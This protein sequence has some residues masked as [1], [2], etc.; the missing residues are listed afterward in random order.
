[1]ENHTW[2]EP[3]DWLARDR[4]QYAD[5]RKRLALEAD[6]KAK[7]S[8]RMKPATRERIMRVQ[9]RAKES[10]KYRSDTQFKLRR[11][12]RTRMKRALLAQG[13]AKTFQSHVRLLGCTVEH[14]QKHIESQFEPWMTWENHGPTGWHIDHIKPLSAFDLT[15]PAQVAEACHFSNLQPLHWQENLAKGGV[16]TRR[17][18]QPTR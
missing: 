14:A 7:P 13:I 10:H 4:K 8:K 17:V 5:F 15:D 9:K 16:K 3:I 12:F 18:S 1:M 6:L 2:G 11:L